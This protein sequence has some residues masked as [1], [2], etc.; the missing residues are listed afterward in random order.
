M[1]HKD[2]QMV[3]SSSRRRFLQTGIAAGALACK[4][5]GFSQDALLS[6]RT[7]QDGA[8]SPFPLASVRLLNGEWKD[9]S[10]KNITYLQTLDVERLL[11]SFRL[12]AGLP[13]SAT[14]YGGWEA[15]SCELRG[16]FAGGHYLSAAALAYASENC[17]GLR[18]SGNRLVAGLAACQHANGNGYL[19]A[20]P[21]DLFKRLAADT[22]VWAPFY[23]YHKILAGLLDMYA[24]AG[25]TEALSLAEGMAAWVGTFFGGLS[26]TQRQRMLK[27]E[28]GGM[29]ESLIDL[30]VMTGKDRYLATARLFEQP[31]F[32]N[33]LIEH[34]DELKSLHANTHIPK[35]LGAAR[36]YEVTG[37]ARYRDGV[38]FFA[39][40][41]ITGRNYVIGNN[42]NGEH[43][44]TDASNLKGTLS[45]T[46]AECCVAYNLM[47]LYRHMFAWTSDSVWMD[48]YERTL[49]NARLGTQNERGLKQYFFPLAAGCWRAYNS[50][51]DSF[52]CCT[53]TGAED[54]A[55]FNGTI[56]YRQGT[57]VLVQQFL[58][59]SLHWA[60]ENFALRQET[61]FPAEPKTRFIIEDPGHKERAIL[62]R[63]P[64]WTTDGS[65]L[66]LNGKVQEFSARPGS[67]VEIRRRW[68]VGD[69]LELALPMSLH[70]EALPGDSETIAA[71]YGPMVLAAKMGAGP[72]SGPGKFIH[73][74]GTAPDPLPPAE[75][76]PAIPAS[77]HGA[78]AS[79]WLHETA[80]GSL[81]F[82]SAESN[83]EVVPM[84]RIKD[85]KY[86]VYWKHA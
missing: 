77:V 81:T 3:T 34:R 63:I 15:P 39:A 65:R 13:S 66:T 78:D 79:A 45:A 8:P 47:K 83:L 32:L 84:F 80:A 53:G 51:E 25:N 11:H 76:L 55:K 7:P 49:L 42:S 54:F 29:N 61:R 86:S 68:K 50:P 22:E 60:E 75:A 56:Y 46:N 40:E 31:S 4:S 21:R 38:E 73:G 72:S 23:T 35:I 85:E 6:T 64:R 52:W 71:M 30:A 57:D 17:T 9:A 28:Y 19:S 62:I 5:Y 48:Q 24:H 18:D 58:A 67:Y 59:S 2:P 82:S 74:R 12:T 36:M 10:N 37:E 43:W 26:D 14:P 41:M 69:V 33:P 1:L 44:T 16:H 70:T 27:T 20:F